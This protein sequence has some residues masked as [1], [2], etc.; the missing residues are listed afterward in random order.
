MVRSF[1][2]VYGEEGNFEYRPGWERIPE[3]WYGARNEYGLVQLNLDL[4]DWT[5]QYPELARFVLIPKTPPNNA[6]TYH[7]QHRWQHRQN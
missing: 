7:P 4:V 5:L 1:F 3:Y 6:L 2:A